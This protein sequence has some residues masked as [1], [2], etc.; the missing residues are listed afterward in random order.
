M[1]LYK[2]SVKES[3]NII[4]IVLRRQLHGTDESVYAGQRDG[5]GWE[6]MMDQKLEK[7]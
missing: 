1:W 6:G 4:C 3:G 7:G 5:T 2:E